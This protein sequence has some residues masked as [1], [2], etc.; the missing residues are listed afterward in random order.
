M[1]QWSFEQKAFCVVP[2]SSFEQ[3]IYKN[4]LKV[5]KED[6]KQTEIHL[7][8]LANSQIEMSKRRFLERALRMSKPFEAT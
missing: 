2:R 1:L 3:S 6:E 4:R 5:F 7:I 8:Y